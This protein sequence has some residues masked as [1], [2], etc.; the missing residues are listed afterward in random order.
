MSIAATPADSSDQQTQSSTMDPDRRQF[1]E[2]VLSQMAAD[3]IDQ[4]RKAIQSINNLLDDLDK[5][6]ENPADI[7][8]DIESIVD[9]VII[10]LISQIDFARDF[11]KLD[12]LALIRR[13]FSSKL[14][15]LIIKACDILAETTQNNLNVQTVLLESG[16][17]KMLVNLLQGSNDET[18]KVKALYAISCLIRDNQRAIHAFDKQCDGLSALLQAIQV[19]S[20]TNKLR[21][22]ASFLISS[23]ASSNDGL[24]ET[25]VKMG[26]VDQIAA[27]L[28]S[29]HDS[30]HE[31]LASA[32][33]SL[34]SSNDQAKEEARRPELNIQQLAEERIESFKGKSE[35]LD[36]ARI[37]QDILKEC[38]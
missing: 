35:H 6:G 22:K 17:L 30:S 28:H 20:V 34:I 32:L 19:T 10:D 29:D 14:P 3:P 12:G 4:L 1:L 5:N 25:M 21:I 23:L 13:F 16:M 15:Q 31:H 18:V 36:E 2:K 8:S 37:F 38:F 11:Y 27:L 24:R 33:L 9:E 7:A 26:F